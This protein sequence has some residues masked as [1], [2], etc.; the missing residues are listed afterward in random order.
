MVKLPG[1]RNLSHLVADDLLARIRAGSIA[2][3]DRLPTE[4]G[5]MDRYGVGRGAVREAIQS[6][7][8]MGVLDVRPGRGAVVVGLGTEEALDTETISAL[9]DRSAIEDLYD[10]RELLEVE[11][12][13]RAAKRAKASAVVEIAE[14]LERLKLARRTGTPSYQADLDFH[15]AVVAASGNVIFLRVLDAVA[16]LL[17]TVRSQTEHVPGAVERAMGEH[18]AIFR[19]IE[20]H[21]PEG[22]RRSTVEHIASGRAAAAEALLMRQSRSG[23]VVASGAA[24]EARSDEGDEVA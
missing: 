6:L 14:A 4:H 11:A 23:A 18:E 24:G 12:A 7:V 21:D 22:A 19:A 3:G 20:E 13:G 1:R 2:P 9:L 5:L 16:D 15:R 17:S 10:F 8:A